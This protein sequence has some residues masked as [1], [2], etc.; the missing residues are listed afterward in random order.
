MGILQAKLL[1]GHQV[2]DHTWLTEISIALE[3]GLLLVYL[4]V[5]RVR[6]HSRCVPAGLFF[7]KQ[8]Q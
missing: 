8:D 2:E 1:G 6:V 3:I 4:F 5:Q 7:T